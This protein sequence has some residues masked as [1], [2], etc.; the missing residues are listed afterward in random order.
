MKYKVYYL[1]P[2]LWIAKR[3]RSKVVMNKPACV[4]WA[5]YI[6]SNQNRHV[7]ISL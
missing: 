7:R 6:R 4:S 1:A 3:V 5:G 2:T